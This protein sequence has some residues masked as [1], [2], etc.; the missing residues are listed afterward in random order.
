LLATHLI[1]DLDSKFTAEFDAILE[2]AKVDVVE[3]APRAPNQNAICERVILSIRSECL[4]NFIVFGETHLK[5]LLENYLCYYN[6]LRPHQGVGNVP[7]RKGEEEP[8]K[9]GKIVCT[10]MLGG[11][12]KL[13]ERQ[14]A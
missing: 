1:H 12:P 10:E 5:Y 8:L 7:L 9:I 13:Y 3:T 2:A 4:N 6:V 11:V 14:A